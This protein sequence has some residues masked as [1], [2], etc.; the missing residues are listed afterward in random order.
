[1]L[2]GMGISAQDIEAQNLPLPK[3]DMTPVSIEEKIICFADKFFSKS[4]GKDFLM[5]EKSVEQVRESQMR[6]N[7]DKVKV[8]DEWLELFGY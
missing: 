1:M 4:K 8:F 5:A 7:P 6:F 3:R 2:V